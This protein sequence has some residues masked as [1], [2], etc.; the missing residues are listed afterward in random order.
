MQRNH[1]G[2]TRRL[3]FAAVVLPLIFT[4]FVRSQYISL[5]T[6]TIHDE[7]IFDVDSATADRITQIHLDAS[8][9]WYFGNSSLTVAY[10]GSM[11]LFQE[12][13]ARNYHYHFLSA[14]MASQ[15][16]SDDEEDPSEDST[17]GTD[18]ASD[19]ATA[20]GAAGAAEAKPAASPVHVDSSDQYLTFNVLGG[21][22]FDKEAYAQYDNS[23]I[24][25][26]VLW[27]QPLSRTVTFDPSYTF[28]YHRYPNLSGITN[29]EHVGA[30]VLGTS[31]VRKS[32]IALTSS[33]GF[34]KYADDSYTYTYTVGHGS[35]AGHGKGGAGGGGGVRTQ[36]VNLTTPSVSQI[37]ASVDWHQ[38][39]A[40]GTDFT[41]GVLYF[42]SP[43]S[44]ARLLPQQRSN[45]LEQ[46]INT[47]LPAT[48]NEIF[49]DHYGYSGPLYQFGAKQS[50][51]LAFSLSIRGLDIRK[52]YTIPAQ[53]F[54]SA[55]ATG[56][57]R[58]DYR[59]EFLVNLSRPFPLGVG[60]SLS[61]ELEWQYIRNDSNVPYYTF[62]KNTFMAGLEF[63]F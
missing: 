28:T 4:G 60:K 22:Q 24:S 30:F 63:N 54:D 55:A 13:V 18:G 49:D 47:A 50:L 32:W 56:G 6:S 11:L 37:L 17:G 45:V 34:K 12:L 61:A 46:Q 8:Q 33:L 2:N 62:S 53:Q 15:Y 44:E 3:F 5:G 10:S 31:A 52:A 19:S 51:P 16:Y 58:L 27:R 14:K 7:N 20:S 21:A 23:L 40:Q 42:G 26:N 38:N 29:T 1:R 36:T 35:K 39:V 43:S 59:T 9:D 41:A 48:E 57:N 25:G